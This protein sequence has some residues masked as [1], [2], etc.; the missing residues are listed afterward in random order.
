MAVQNLKS[1][2]E[3]RIYKKG[4]REPVPAIFDDADS[5]RI[6]IVVKNEQMAI[7]KEGIDRVE[8]RPSPSQSHQRIFSQKRRIRITPRIHPEG[9]TFPA[10]LTA[11]TSASVDRANSIF[12]RYI[13]DLRAIT[14]NAVKSR[15]CG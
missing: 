11:Q 8:A 12:R 6:V 10:S 5:E 4:A 15:L 14:V 7:L 3:L 1:R 13:E 2:S 9:R